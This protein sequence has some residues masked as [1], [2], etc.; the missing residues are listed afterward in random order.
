MCFSDIKPKDKPKEEPKKEDKKA[1]NI[2]YAFSYDFVEP[3]KVIMEEDTDDDG[4]KKLAD[5]KEEIIK[6]G[7]RVQ[8]PQFYCD[9]LNFDILTYYSS[10]E[11]LAF[12]IISDFS[13]EITTIV[14][15]NTTDL[16][17]Y[18]NWRKLHKLYA[19]SNARFF[20]GRE[21]VC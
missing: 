20:A 17:F 21:K 3:E 18:G 1:N 12:L 16:D 6:A 5:L 4:E 19:Q 14:T 15:A 10:P 2:E 11:D 13:K 8:Y 7:C 9:K